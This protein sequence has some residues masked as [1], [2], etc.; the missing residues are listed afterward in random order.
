MNLKEIIEKNRSSSKKIEVREE[1]FVDLNRPLILNLF[2]LDV[3]GKEAHDEDILRI[4]IGKVDSLA[5][6]KRAA[7]QVWDSAYAI[8]G[9][10]LKLTKDGVYLTPEGKM[11]LK[12]R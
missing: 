10:K 7:K 2:G 1:D 5:K 11:V 9:K 12:P 8:H 3:Y 4:I 6:F